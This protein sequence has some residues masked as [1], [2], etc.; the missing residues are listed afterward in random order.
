MGVKHHEKGKVNS[1]LT[2]QHIGEPNCKCAADGDPYGAGEQF[3]K[4]AKPDAHSAA[5]NARAR[6][7]REQP[8]PKVPLPLS[9]PLPMPLPPST[10]LPLPTTQPLPT[11]FPPPTLLPLPSSQPA[12][13]PPSASF[14]LFYMPNIP[15]YHHHYH[16]PPPLSQ[17]SYSPSQGASLYYPI[18]TYSF[19]PQ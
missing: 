1:A 3:G 12:L 8:A 17:L 9:Q 14:P 15:Y 2:A 5:T 4:C 13:F 18:S 11:L 6:A 7:A 10:P 19:P 16:P